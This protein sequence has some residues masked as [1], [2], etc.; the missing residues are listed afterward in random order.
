MAALMA[1]YIRAQ[2]FTGS[3]IIGHADTFDT[4][5]E[6]KNL[7]MILGAI[8]GGV[9]GLIVVVRSWH[10]PRAMFWCRYWLK[11]NHLRTFP[12][13]VS[14]CPSKVHWSTIVK[15]YLAWPKTLIEAIIFGWLP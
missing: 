7:A 8:P 2:G 12:V 3:V 9:K 13:A 10:A 14:W 15:E 6:M 1:R 4:R 11:Q 5:G